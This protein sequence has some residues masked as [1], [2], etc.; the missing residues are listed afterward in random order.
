MFVRFG[1]FLLAALVML[2]GG[3]AS[4]TAMEVRVTNHSVATSCAEEDNVDFRLS[5]EGVGAF[6]VE[7]VQPVYGPEIVVDS[8]DPDWRDCAVETALNPADFRFEPRDVVLFENEA[9][10]LRGY[11]F[12][13]FWRAEQ[14]LVRVGERSETGL[15][16]L[17]LW[18][19]TEEGFEEVMAIYPTDGYWRLRPLPL[20]QLDESAYG[21]S[22]L[23]GPVEE[24][25][26]PIVDLAAITFDPAAMTFEV[27]FRRGG[28]ARIQV[29]TIDRARVALEIA[30]V[31]LPGTGE[32]T[33]AAAR[34]M[35]VNRYRA[36]ASE[37]E[38]HNRDGIG[39]TE[40]VM[41]AGTIQA[42]AVRLGRSEISMH[43][44]S[45]P[46]IVFGNFASR[47]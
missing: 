41:A 37:L 35:Y 26:R 17:Q 13:R 18:F 29:A 31:G 7:A 27:E 10:R 11:R 36:D 44:T 39:W 9:L 3:M 2:G 45:A 46:D 6:R 14:S 38:W 34:S 47:R 32:Q 33:F 24:R 15:H 23:I 20:P 12:D 4:A 1:R 25:G 21:T 5:G 40:P 22:V 42:T 28:Q 16:L 8:T 30:F 43:N 19:R